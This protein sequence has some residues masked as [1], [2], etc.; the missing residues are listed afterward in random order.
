MLESIL[1]QNF[2]IHQTLQLNLKPFNILIGPNSSGKSSIFQSILILKNSL[3]S[4]QNIGIAYSHGSYD[5]GDFEDLVSLRKPSN[6]I[7]IHVVGFKKLPHGLKENSSVYTKYAYKLVFNKEGPQQ[8]YLF[9]TVDD[10][11]ITFDWKQNKE[12]KCRIIDQ[13]NPKPLGA[14]NLQMV[15]LHPRFATNSGNAEF[16]RKFNQLF[17]NGDFTKDLLG[18]FRVVPYNR[19]ATT[20]GGQLMKD[21]GDILSS[22]A[23]H[24]TSRLIT[25][26]SKQPELLTQVSNF[27]ERLTGK[28][29]RPRNV[30]L[31][32]LTDVPGVTLDF[33]KEGFYNAIIHE[34]T[35]PNQV[36]LLLATLLDSE[37]GST[38]AIEEPEIHLHPKFQSSLAKIIIEIAKSQSKQIIFTTHSEHMLYPFLA[39]IA[40]KNK[41]SLL[42]NDVAIYYFEYPTAKLESKVEKL[43][44]NEHGQISGGLKGFW[45]SDLE[46]FKEFSGKHE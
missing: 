13:A 35:G 37:E 29:I 34:G 42:I 36:I 17:Q 26:L 18:N 22:E 38:I 39:S 4:K 20:Y 2:K 45:E 44:I 9:L 43:G 46:I 31:S 5:Y 28:S 14:V 25:N 23:Q 19:S 16:Q 32:R 11:E 15:G 40:S 6:D 12:I 41:N 1:L 24:I 33:V 3:S 30:D 21:V 27:I 7:T 8:V 10:Y